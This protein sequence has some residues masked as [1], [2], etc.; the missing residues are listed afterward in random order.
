MAVNN[1]KKTIT[2]VEPTPWVS[3][4]NCK[5]LSKNY[6]TCKNLFTLGDGWGALKGTPN[7]AWASVFFWHPLLPVF[8]I[9]IVLVY[10]RGKRIFVNSSYGR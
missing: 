3:L 1:H 6:I 8:S 7:K 2:S 10:K 4:I 5:A 9:F